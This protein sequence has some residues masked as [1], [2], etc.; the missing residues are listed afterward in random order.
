MQFAIIAKDNRKARYYDEVNHRMSSEP[1]DGTVYA[2]RHTA[3]NQ[4]ARID[5]ATPLEVVLHIQHKPI[6]ANPF[7]N[8][9]VLTKPVFVG[10]T[11]EAL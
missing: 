8:C 2:D 3:E 7:R 6:L 5:T 11:Y 10:P 1:R 4:L 9:S